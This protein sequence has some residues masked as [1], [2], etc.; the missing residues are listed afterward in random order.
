MAR[1]KSLF[2]SYMQSWCD[3]PVTQMTTVIVLT[4]S[5]TVVFSILL[6]TLNLDSLLT[7]WGSESQITIY[8]KENLS[9][10]EIVITHNTLKEFSEFKEIQYINKAQAL[11]EFSSQMK[12]Y[13][14][15][16]LEDKEM[17]RI[18]PNN[19][20]VT[21]FPEVSLS[22]LP[23]ISGQIKTLSAVEDISYGQ[24]W[25]VQ[26][27]AILDTIKGGGWFINLTAILSVFFII[28]NIIRM[29]MAQKR[30]EIEILEL[31]G[32][33]ART[34]RAPFVFE[35]ALTGFLGSL[36]GMSMSYA[37][38]MI[39][40]HFLSSTLVFWRVSENIQFLSL[41]TTTV[42]LLVGALFGALGS[43]LCVTQMN[44]FV[45]GGR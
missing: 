1:L 15:E 31:V 21:L 8:L 32:A 41:E 7:R 17:E 2:S 10:E 3:H 26:Y 19:F 28:G 35:G 23:Q 39:Q 36:L 5:Y 20:R 42:C 40:K 22:K 25:V 37:L 44:T 12:E 24:D 13:M 38:I 30:Q 18:F 29:N 14:P 45:P 34:I 33:T 43:Y 11:E 27:G 4:F 9:Q 6:L 16:V